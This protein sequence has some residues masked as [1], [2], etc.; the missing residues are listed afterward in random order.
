M[1]I[2]SWRDGIGEVEQAHEALINGPEGLSKEAKKT[3]FETTDSLP[4]LGRKSSAK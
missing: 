3:A 2:D 1:V 4:S